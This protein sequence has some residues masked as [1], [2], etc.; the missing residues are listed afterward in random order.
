MDHSI[1]RVSATALLIKSS[2]SWL[3]VDKGRSS[4]MCLV[5]VETKSGF[6]GHGLTNLADGPTVAR[7]ANTAAA[8]AIVGMDALAHER[9]SQALYWS[10]TSSAQSGIACNAMSAIDVALWDIKGKVL[11]QPIWQ[12]LGGARDRL[13]VYATIGVPGL[14]NE[15]IVEIARRL[16]GLGFKAI[17]VQVGRPG[18]DQR[19]SGKS[20]AAM[21]A[22]DLG[23]L[24]ALRD[25]LGSKLEIAI[26]GA[27]RFD[28]PHA[29]ELARRARELDVA[30]Y[31]EPVLQN[32]VELMAEIRRLT[33]IR[34]SCG[35]NE[36]LITRFRDMIV[37]KAVDV[38]Q[39]NVGIAGGFT[40]GVKIAGL[41]AAFNMPVVSGGGSLPFHNMHLQAGVSNGT[42]L[43]YQTS[44]TSAYEPLFEGLPKIENGF[45][46]LPRRPGLGFAPRKEAVAAF[47]VM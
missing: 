32:D 33:G 27:S 47:A 22:E 45:I 40:N 31:E 41:A 3:G 37:A 44:A 34:V 43:E 10:L 15:E 20:L 38:V 30:W 11:E 13:P 18:L 5:E 36:G 4:S 25:A 26:D 39:P 12:L 8:Q 46:A 42:M 17:K 23:R 14:T 29:L 1:T 2:M 35:Q 19:G 9:V 28:L 24:R 6:I 16:A 21:M 7:L